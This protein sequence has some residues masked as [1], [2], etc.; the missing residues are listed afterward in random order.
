MGV[1]DSR[2]A[3]LEASNDLRP[4][5]E[6]GLAPE[7]SR[8]QLKLCW[9]FCSSWHS[10]VW[11]LASPSPPT[12]TSCGP[13]CNHTHL[14][15]EQDEPQKRPGHWPLV[16][17]VFKDNDVHE[18]RHHLE[19]RVQWR[20]WLRGLPNL[21]S[22]MGSPSTLTSCQQPWG[23][24]LDKKLWLCKPLM[25]G[26]L[27]QESQLPEEELLPPKALVRTFWVGRSQK[28]QS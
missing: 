19:D 5:G 28:L 16:P 23:L 6:Y 20:P 18:D 14:L 2:S 3:A 8:S 7:C 17:T 26:T 22:F 25:L 12:T 13:S 11:C 21:R 10:L 9:F 4:L 27:G 24:L 15:V 1:L